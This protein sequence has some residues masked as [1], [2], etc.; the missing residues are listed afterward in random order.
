MAQV[1]DTTSKNMEKVVAAGLINSVVW[2]AQPCPLVPST[3]GG[4]VV[5]EGMKLTSVRRLKE[6]VSEV[7]KNKVSGTPVR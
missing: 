4:E 2:K 7:T 6:R 1:F 3:Q 5:R